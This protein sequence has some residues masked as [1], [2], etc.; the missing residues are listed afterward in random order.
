MDN[1]DAFHVESQEDLAKV[2]VLRQR[3]ESNLELW[4]FQDGRY[5]S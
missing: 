4:D 5:I 2:G 3:Q 1:K